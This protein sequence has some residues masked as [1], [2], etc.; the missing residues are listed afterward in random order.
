MPTMTSEVPYMSE[1]VLKHLVGGTITT[2]LTSHDGDSF[3]FMVKKPD[4]DRL[5][6]WA[7]M[8]AE[9]NGPGWLTIMDAKTGERLD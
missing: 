4:G 3:G 8:D 7:D 9:G 1:K 2:A 6:V 5:A